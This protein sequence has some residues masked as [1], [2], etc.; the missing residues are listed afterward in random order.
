MAEQELFRLIDK[1]GND[2]VVAAFGEVQDYVERL[3]R[4]RIADLPDGTWETDRP[5]RLRPGRRR[6]PG[7]RSSVKLTI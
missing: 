3:T 4:A 5:R 7:H 1:Y 2:D 6:G